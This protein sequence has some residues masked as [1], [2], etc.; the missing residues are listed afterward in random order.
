M[1]EVRNS[2][3]RAALADPSGGGFFI[4]RTTSPPGAVA[5]KPLARRALPPTSNKE[6]VPPSWAVTVRATP[7]RR[8]PLPEWYPR[9]PLRDITSVVK[10]MNH[11]RRLCGK[12]SE[13]TGLN[14]EC[15]SDAVE[16]KSRLGNAAVRQQIQLSEDSSRS[17]DPATPV[18]KEEGVPQSTPTPPTQKALDAAAP[19]P[20]STQAVASTSTAY[21]A[22]GKPKASS[23]SPSDSSFQTP[24][25][26]NDPALAD[27]ME[28]ELSS[29]IEQIEKMVRKN[30]KRAPKAA[31]PSKVTIQ[32]RTLLSMR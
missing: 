12:F 1:P 31:Q 28:K 16:R 23:S 8:S 18:Q 11:S 27:L 22:E 21:L 24:S 15:S 9:S 7:K 4:R 6:N 26:P 13:I 29:S 32:K 5:V 14:F 30:L 10:V 3:G 19:C 20:G 2:G 25:R 17:V